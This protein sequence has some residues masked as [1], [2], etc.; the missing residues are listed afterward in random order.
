MKMYANNGGIPPV[1]PIL[2]SMGDKRPEF[3]KIAEHVKKYG[4]VETTRGETM[5]IL[6][7]LSDELTSIWTGQ[8]S[9]D[10]GLKIAQ[11]KVEE[12]LGR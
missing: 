4:F 12:L 11:R 6:K 5:S 9:V 7:I 1:E 2:M 10:E 8:V 3:P